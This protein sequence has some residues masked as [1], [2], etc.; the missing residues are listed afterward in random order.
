MMVAII[1]CGDFQS[2]H[3]LGKHDPLKY[4]RSMLCYLV[5]RLYYAFRHDMLLREIVD[6]INVVPPV[7]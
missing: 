7:L 2:F 5:C 4:V 1:D 6:A 3:G